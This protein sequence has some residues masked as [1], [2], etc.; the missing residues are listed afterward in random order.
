M[1]GPGIA[2]STAVVNRSSERGFSFMEIVVVVAIIG[3]MGA[4]AAGVTMIAV[5]AFGRLA[6]GHGPNTSMTRATPAPPANPPDDG[7]A[8]RD[9]RGFAT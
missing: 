7:A 5:V 3:I 9:H 2:V 8:R 1:N 6:P 4:L